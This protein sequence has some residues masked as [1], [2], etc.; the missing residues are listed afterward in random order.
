[1]LL[2]IFFAI[3]GKQSPL[4]IPKMRLALSLC[5]WT[6]LCANVAMFFRMMLRPRHMRKSK[7][8]WNTSKSAFL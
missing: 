4:S 8:K 3:L 1:M 7:W 6:F 5:Q 2:L